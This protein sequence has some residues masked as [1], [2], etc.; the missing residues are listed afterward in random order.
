[1]TL[2]NENIEVVEAPSPAPPEQSGKPKRAL[3]GWIGVG[4]AVSAAS[5]LAVTVFTGDDETTTWTGDAKDHPNFG[6]VSVAVWPRGDAKDHPN[7][8]QITPVVELR[9]DAKD[10]P[11]YGQIT[12][13]VELRGD[14]KDHPNYG[15]VLAAP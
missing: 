7:Y 12:P 15:P 4:V 9:G 5:V 13:V 14:A 1:M 6:G 10:H 8:G 11:N 2:T 3:L